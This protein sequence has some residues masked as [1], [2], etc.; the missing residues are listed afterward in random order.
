MPN[1]KKKYQVFISS[2]YIDL[3]KERESAVEA[4]LKSGNIP[5]GMELFKSGQSQLKTI[6]RWIRESDIYLLI[7]GK[8]YG[9]IDKETKLSYTEIECRYA[10][11]LDMPVFAIVMEDCVANINEKNGIPH[12]DIFEIDNIDKYNSFSEYVKTKV[13]R[14]AKNVTEVSLRI[15]ENIN[16]IIFDNELVGLLCP[17]NSMLANSIK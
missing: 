10:L 14:F 8:R 16:D 2:T 13:V 4:V 11:E 3:I 5:A 6:K 7:L 9:S 15:H 12:G 1:L 17:G